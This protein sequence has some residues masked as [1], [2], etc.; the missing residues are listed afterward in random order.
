MEGARPATDCDAVSTR[1]NKFSNL[2]FAKTSIDETLLTDVSF[3]IGGVS[4]DPEA[5]EEEVPSVVM[6]VEEKH[7]T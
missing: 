2:P 1:R 3:G 6:F 7:R 4:H 5:E